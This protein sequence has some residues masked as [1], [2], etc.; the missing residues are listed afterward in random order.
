[1]IQINFEF[2]Y[3]IANVLAILLIVGFLWFIM[4]K[5]VFE[6]N[7]VIREFFDLNTLPVKPKRERPIVKVNFKTK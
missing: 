1:M 7:P 6:P 3:I 5:F 2:G 4:W